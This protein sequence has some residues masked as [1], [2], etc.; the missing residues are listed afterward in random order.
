MKVTNHYWRRR[1]HREVAQRLAAAPCDAEKTISMLSRRPR[2]ALTWLDRL[3]SIL[4]TPFKRLGISG[5]EET[6]CDAR[7]AG[8]PVRDAQHST[9]GF[10]TIDVFLSDFATG[11]LAADLSL[12]DFLRLEIEPGTAA[13]EICKATRV[14][15]DM[16][17]SFGG[18]LVIDRDDDFLE[19]HPDPDFRIEN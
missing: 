14:R 10:W 3:L 16:R 17:L 9:D 1:L 12:P 2:P 4:T 13:H 18:A 6:G 19:I 5:W 15:K 8:S 11:S 7:G